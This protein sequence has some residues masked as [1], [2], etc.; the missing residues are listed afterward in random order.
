MTGN[1]PPFVEVIPAEALASRARELGTQLTEEYRNR[2]PVFVGVL[3]GSLPFLSDLVR[4]VKVSLDV[5]FLALS[6][7]GEGGKVR[8]AMDTEISLEG[9]DV[10][11]VEDIVDTG[12]TLSYLRR[13]LETRDVASLAT[14]TL[15][16]KAPRRIVD[17]PLEYRGFEVGDEFLLGYGLDWEGKYRNL[18]SIWVVL[19]LAAFQSYPASLGERVFSAG[20]DNLVV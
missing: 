5:D 20:G 15:L 11:V 2:E 7:F 10:V 13:L 6:R 17:V 3:Q 4:Q 12:L 9:R 18:R 1:N 8:I 19:D 14:V 16:D